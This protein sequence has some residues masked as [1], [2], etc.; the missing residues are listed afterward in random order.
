MIP[1]LSLKN[2]IT[3]YNPHIIISI[4]IICITYTTPYAT[5]NTPTITPLYHYTT[6]Y[7]SS[8]IP[9]QTP[10]HNL[11]PTQPCT[12]VFAI[13]G[14][15]SKIKNQ[16]QD[17]NIHAYNSIQSNPI[18]SN[19]IYSHNSKYLPFYL[20]HIIIFQISNTNSKYYPIPYQTKPNP[21]YKSAQLANHLIA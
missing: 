12:Y 18:Q 11:I 3:Q 6:T 1:S 19:L 5:H 10:S 21:P 2:L 7:K 8:Q 17:K 13:E 20:H 9:S 15:K 14:Q 16:Y 4:Y